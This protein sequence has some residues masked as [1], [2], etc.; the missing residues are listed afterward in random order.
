[1]SDGIPDGFEPQVAI[2]TGAGRGIG[3]ATAIEL[4]DRGWAV[5]LV[6]RTRDELE[7]TAEACAGDTLL[8]EA[9]LTDPVTPAAVISAAVEG[10]GRLDG[11]VNNAGAAPMLP[12]EET[13]DDVLRLAL[14]TNLVA[15]FRLARAAWPHLKTGGGTIVNLSSLSAIDPFPGFS[16]Y[17][18][19]KGGLNG[20]TVALA[21][22]GA[23]HSIRC[24]GVA[25][26][27]VETGMFRALPGMDAVPTEALLDPAEVARVIADVLDGPL[28]YASGETISLRKQRG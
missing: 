28:A 13:G 23:E 5:L 14:E 20:L 6:S 15:S 24:V 3:R 12:L 25:P 7:A 17:A 21:K 27:G 4:C 11:L 16:A 8:F 9:D 10:F 26:A 2:V 18:A 19:A 1:M 22:E